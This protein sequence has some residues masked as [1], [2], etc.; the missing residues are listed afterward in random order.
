M[1][2]I[3]V[4]IFPLGNLMII[5]AYVLVQLI[6]KQINIFIL[7]IFTN[8]LQ[9][10]FEQ[11]ILLFGDSFIND[12]FIIVFILMVLNYDS[13]DSLKISFIN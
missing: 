13:L 4:V 5:T 12:L 7:R 6:K 2:E 8:S 9:L 1:M 11:V 10:G 3:M